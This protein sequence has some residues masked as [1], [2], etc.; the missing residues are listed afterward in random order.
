MSTVKAWSSCV[1]S[2]AFRQ[3]LE[4]NWNLLPINVAP[5]E[6]DLIVVRATSDL[7]AYTTI[8]NPGGREVRIYEG[9]EFMGVLGTR[10]S[11][12]NPTGFLP[13][14]V[15]RR[16]DLLNLVAVGGLIAEAIFTPRYYGGRTLAVETIGFPS[17]GLDQPVNMRQ[18]A[19][20]LGTERPR[21]DG[22]VLF[23]LGTSAEAG[24]TTF[25]CEALRSIYRQG[26]CRRV[27]AIKACGTGRLRDLLRYLDAG[28]SPALDFVDV[29]WPSTYNISAEEYTALL[30]RLIAASQREA[31]LT[32]V[33]VGGDLLEARA[34]EAVAVASRLRAPLVLCVNDAMGAL[35]GLERLRREPAPEIAIASMNQNQRA[36]A[37]RLELSNVIDPQSPQDVDRFIHRLFPMPVETRTTANT[38]L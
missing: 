33:E 27:G 32:F 4:E 12:R 6:G 13:Q 15:L 9:D 14:R 29:G 8:E 28:A 20:D 17:L 1:R 24:K 35:A 10:K 3:R 30:M 11:G 16:G 36:L 19:R 38:Q 18:A 7:G 23:V 34:P 37:E 5:R 21:S 31:D 26:A 25:L 2:A 22:S